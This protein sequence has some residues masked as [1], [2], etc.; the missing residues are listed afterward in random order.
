MRLD[1]P[2]YTQQ[3]AIGPSEMPAFLDVPEDCD[4]LALIVPA[5]GCSRHVVSDNHLA[6]ALRKRGYATL[7]VDYVDDWRRKRPCDPALLARRLGEALDWIDAVP[8]FAPLPLML[9]HTDPVDPAIT[10]ALATR[11]PRTAGATLV[12]ADQAFADRPRELVEQIAS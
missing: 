11:P 3:L 8:M 2:L 10:D 9:V 1:V 6:A 12:D 4:A 5:C 7:I